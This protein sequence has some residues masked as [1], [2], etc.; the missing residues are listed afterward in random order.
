MKKNLMTLQHFITG[1]YCPNGTKVSTQFPCPQGTFNN[2]TGL[3]TDTDCYPCLGVVTTAPEAPFYPYLPC[4]AGFYCRTGA[5]T[6][7]PMQGS[8]AYECPVGHYCPEQTIEPIHCPSGTYSNTVRLMNV[9]DCTP[10]TKG[11]RVLLVKVC[12]KDEIILAC[13]H[14]SNGRELTENIEVFSRENWL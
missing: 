1:Y 5:Q 8:D 10:C 9:T 3:A 4:S 12:T 2:G 14:V 7:A 13:N 11:E 6:A